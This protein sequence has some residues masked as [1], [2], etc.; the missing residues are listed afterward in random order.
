MCVLTRA[1]V[2]LEGRI[3]V[4][5]LCPADGGAATLCRLLRQSTLFSPDVRQI[6]SDPAR[7]STLTQALIDCRREFSPSIVF[8]VS[9][10][11]GGDAAGLVRELN[12]IFECGVF[13]IIDTRGPQETVALLQ[14]GA[15]DVLSPPLASRDLLPRVWRQLD[16]AARRRVDTY[17]LAE[18][19]G[20]RSLIGQAHDFLVAVRKIPVAAKCDAGVLLAG[21]TGTGKELFARAVHYLSARATRPFISVNCG[22]IP[23]DLIENELFGHSAGAY[24]GANASHAGVVAESEGG[25]L[26]LDEI[27]SLP[28]LAQVK[29][30]RFLQDREFRPLGGSR[31]RKADVRVIAATNTNLEEALNTGRLRRDLYYRLN[32]FPIHLPPLRERRRDIALLAAHFLQKYATEFDKPVTAID[33]D[34]MIA[35]TSYDWP[36]NVRELEHIVQRAV[37]LCEG[38]FLRSVDIVLPV[39]TARRPLSFREAKAREVAQFERRYLTDLLEL[40]AGNISR[41]ARAAQKNRRAF[42]ELLRKHGLSRT[43]QRVV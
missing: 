5:D 20:L 19:F 6:S 26:F 3:L 12:G 14:A 11:A 4:V 8:L 28:L 25:T 42:F 23:T 17:A 1:P 37:L 35:L 13:A 16:Y 7:R 27:D 9:S 39:A 38:A 30:L 33:A 21:E 2:T 34:A 43:N 29:L 22:A 10:P 36:G 15:I 32:V 41:A 40:H 31:T 24:T 18:H